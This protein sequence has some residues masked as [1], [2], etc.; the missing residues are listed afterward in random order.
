MPRPPSHELTD[1]EAQIMSVVWNHGPCTAERIRETL[2]DPLHDSTVRTLLRV[3]ESKGYLT[4][5]PHGRKYYYEAAVARS[6][7]ERRA[8]RALVQRLFGGSVSALAQRL[9]ED[10]DLTPEG[11][12]AIRE[13]MRETAVSS[14]ENGQR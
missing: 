5:R 2:P 4:H 3:L 12:A 10:E 9:I 8:V 11:L 7:A 6:S 1:R 14:E 13:R